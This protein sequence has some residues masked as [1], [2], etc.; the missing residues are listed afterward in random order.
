MKRKRLFKRFLSAVVVSALVITTVVGSIGSKS[1]AANEA[2]EEETMIYSN[3]FESSD[4][5]SIFTVGDT[6]AF[7]KEVTFDA[8]SGWDTQFRED[9]AADY[10]GAVKKG[11]VLSY[12]ILIPADSSFSGTLKIQGIMKMGDSWE[13][14][15][16]DIIKELMIDSFEQKEGYKKA[17][18]DIE[19]GSEVEKN[20]GIK[21]IVPSVS[22]YQCDYSGMM[23][24]DNIKLTEGGNKTDEPTND[25]IPFTKTSSEQTPVSIE[26]S[27]VV[28][29][30]KSYSEANVSIVDKNA[31]DSTYK[32]YAYLKA[33]GESDSVIMGHQNDTH[34]KQ[35]LV[36]DEIDGIHSDVYDVTGSIAGVMGIDTLSLTSNEYC[37]DLGMTPEEVVKQCVELTKLAADN[38]AIITLSSHMVNFSRFVDK[39]A[40]KVVDGKLDWKKADFVSVGNETDGAWVT[41][42]DIV[43]R[44]MPNGDL[45]YLFTSYLD[46]IAAYAKELEVYNIPVLFRPFHENTGSWFWWGAAFCD[47]QAYK[48]LYRYAVN[49]LRDEK[50]VHNFI[51]VYSPGSEADSVEEFSERYP[52]D[53]Y[54]DMVGIDMYHSNPA[55]GDNFIESLVGKLGILQDFANQHN[56]VTA[57]T[58]TGTSISST[59]TPLLISGNT[60]LD[61]YN[62]VLEAVTSSNLKISYFLTW[63]N[64]GNGGFY[65]PYVNS[66]SEDGTKVGHEMGDYFIDF[67][68][69]PKSIF[70][71]QNPDYSKLTTKN[72]TTA[73]VTGYIYVPFSGDRILEAA[74]IRAVVTGAADDT[75]IAFRFT[76]KEGSV[77][78][79][80]EA[81]KQGDEYVATLD[82]EH[83]QSL[84]TTTG[85]IRLVVN[86]S[87]VA[88]QTADYTEYCD[89][90][91]AK[92]NMK[93]KEDYIYEVD[94]FEAYYGDDNMLGSVWA[95]NKASGCQITPSL[96]TDYKYGGDYGLKFEYSLTGSSS[97]E[98]WLGVTKSLSKDWSDYN[99]LQLWVYPDG[100]GQKL[101][102]QI[103]TDGED[104][105]VWLPDVAAKTEPVLLTIPFSD[106]KGKNNG[107]FNPAS[108]QRFGIWCNSLIDSTELKTI[109]SAMYFDEIRAVNTEKN[110][111]VSNALAQVSDVEGSANKNIKIVSTIDTD[112]LTA[113][114][115]VGFIVS[116]VKKDLTVDDNLRVGTN[117]VYTSILASGK[118]ITPDEVDKDGKY[119]F[120][121]KIKNIPDKDFDTEIYV[122]SY[123]KTPSGE[124]VYGEVQTFSVN[125]ILNGEQASAN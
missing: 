82:E 25:N 40:D 16:S 102:I 92:F 21:A 71:K 33:V 35:G 4:G 14:T 48:N 76:N 125:Y 77:S 115:E 38:G 117:T 78:F 18:V 15:Q 44:V 22:G 64:F 87:D 51:Y 54:V 89:E 11:A 61:W 60:R 121:A 32:L 103:T 56:K 104:F 30:G 97:S 101:V 65:T 80:I 83:L 63:A 13:W 39:N 28:I 84:G 86:G 47:A 111:S 110:V 23:Y 1:N 53:D 9:I 5:D 34:H 88:K 105:E 96:S 79:D 85:T 123:G 72:D 68:N 20:V 58:E 75:K 45:N 93:Q 41:E 122:R 42:G 112:D 17:S 114:D 120:T 46:M 50:G 55:Q 3:D 99:A 107:T 95:V 119:I 81:A 73:D 98:G 27:N 57:L 62:E 7:G 94:D 100:Y 43:S 52:G 36:A 19:F 91:N 8:T 37:Y 59:N 24:I 116:T 109:D 69:S 12:D 31:T 113:L 6:K 29:N 74:E 67:Y 108:V 10:S 26:G 118:T 70:A 106:F 124:V 49:Y 2:S 66:I 90:I